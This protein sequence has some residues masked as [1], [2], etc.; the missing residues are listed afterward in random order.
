MQ[1]N[2]TNIA[3]RT[4]TTLIYSKAHYVTRCNRMKCNVVIF[5]S[6]FL[7]VNKRMFSIISIRSIGIYDVV[8]E[9][10]SNYLKTE[11]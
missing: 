10:Y 6:A 9:N 3:V 2:L 7:F 4:R 1:H 5:L 8:V 11:Q